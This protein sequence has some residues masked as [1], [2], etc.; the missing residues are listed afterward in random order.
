[1]LLGASIP[2]K[3]VE[4]GL[5]IFPETGS[6]AVPVSQLERRCRPSASIGAPATGGRETLGDWGFRGCLG[7]TV[8]PGSPG[9]GA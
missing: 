2:D 7:P 9:I 6:G 5:E 4:L 1:M 3:G 8:V